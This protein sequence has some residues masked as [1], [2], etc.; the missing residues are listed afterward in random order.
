MYGYIE[1][2]FEGCWVKVILVF[3]CVL[4][5]VFDVVLLEFDGV[6]DSVFYL[7]NCQGECY[8]EYLVDYG[9][10]VDLLEELFFF[11][12]QQYYLYLF[13]GCLLVLDGDFQVEV[14]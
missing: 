11:Y 9:Q 7:F 4:C 5:C 8:M 2:Y 6:V 14:G 12:L 1:L 3:N 10:F 13:F